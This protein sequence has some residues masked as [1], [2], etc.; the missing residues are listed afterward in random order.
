MIKPKSLKSTDESDNYRTAV[1]AI[2][3]LKLFGIKGSHGTLSL[4]GESKE[5]SKLF[6]YAISCLNQMTCVLNK[7][8]RARIGFKLTP[9]PL[10]R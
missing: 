5:K 2:N 3:I 4:G 8:I 7:N 1:F 9:N 10:L 6:I